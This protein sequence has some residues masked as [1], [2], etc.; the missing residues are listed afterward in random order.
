[1]VKVVDANA[2]TIVVSKQIEKSSFDSDDEEGTLVVEEPVEVMKIPKKAS[3]KASKS[4][5]SS[6]TETKKTK[7][8]KKSVDGEENS[9]SEVEEKPKK[10]KKVDNVEEKPK[11]ASKKLQSQ[12]PKIVEEEE[13]PQP[14]VEK[15]KATKKAKEIKK[16]VSSDSEDDTKQ[17]RHVSAISPAFLKAVTA[18]TKYDV[19]SDEMKDICESFIKVMIDK[20][21]SGETVKFTNHFAFKMEHRATRNFMVPTKDKTADP[22]TVTKPERYAFTMDV[23]P[24]LKK[25]FDGIEVTEELTEKIG[26]KKKG[27]DDDSES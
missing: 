23:R 16:K 19:K 14:I 22:K 7:N 10:S 25:M 1:M 2:N 3:K 18:A 6:D 13:E 20:V 5:T 26:K 17:K 4:G 15:P 8:S 11:K 9:S 12:P 27:G 21:M 24:S